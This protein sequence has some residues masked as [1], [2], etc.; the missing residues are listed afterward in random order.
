MTP[1]VISVV[2]FVV[3]A[4]FI[5]NTFDIRTARFPV[6]VWP[7]CA[8]GLYTV[9]LAA[10]IAVVFRVPTQFFSAIGSRSLYLFSLE[11]PLSYVVSKITYGKIPYPLWVKPHSYWIEPLRMAVI[12]T[13]AF[14]LSYP[15]QWVLMYLRQRL[16]P[17]NTN[18]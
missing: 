9:F 15:T 12:L 3:V 5:K 8:L 10:K 4:F 16:A 7:I 13:M 2:L 17:T 14:A 1:F 6:Q 11:L 18:N